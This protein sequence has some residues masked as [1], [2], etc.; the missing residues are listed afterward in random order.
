[1]QIEDMKKRLEEM[2]RDIRE[3]QAND[4]DS[5]ELVQKVVE[6][7]RLAREISKQY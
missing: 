4:E 2:K 5:D 7:T 1:M 3:R 6:C